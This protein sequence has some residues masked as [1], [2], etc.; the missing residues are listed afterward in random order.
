M[1]V[2]ISLAEL[3]DMISARMAKQKPMGA[4]T[5]WISPVPCERIGD[6]PNWRLSGAG[7]AGHAEAWER[8]R[9]EF[10]D[11]YDLAVV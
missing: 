4:G 3:R 5:F 2:P 1:R 8:V 7:P 10:E 11:R 6:G 9:S